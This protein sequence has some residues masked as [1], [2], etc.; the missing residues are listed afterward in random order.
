LDAGNYSVHNFYVEVLNL[1]NV[2]ADLVCTALN[3]LLL[4][5]STGLGTAGLGLGLGLGHVG[6]GLGLGVGPAGHGL[7][8]GTVGL[9]LG[10]GL[11]RPGNIDNICYLK[12]FPG[13]QPPSP[14]REEIQPL[15]YLPLTPT[16]KPLA[17]PLTAAAMLN[18]TESESPKTP[19]M[20]SIALLH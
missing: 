16:L 1:L 9:G 5:V 13:A 2:S 7:G 8:L 20:T 12:I 18:K 4:L 14:Q 15:P 3:N 17:S 6:L 11:G 10:L 19:S